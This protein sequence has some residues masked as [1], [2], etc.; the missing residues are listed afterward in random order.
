MTHPGFDRRRLVSLAAVLTIAVVAA[1]AY[2]ARRQPEPTHVSAQAAP[3]V[4]IKPPLQP[5]FIAVA[6]GATPDSNP[7]SLE[8]NLALAHAVLPGPG[9]LLFGSGP[10]GA[11]VQVLD[12]ALPRDPLLDALGE[13][14]SPRAGRDSRYES[15]SLPA[16][17]ATL[18]A[19]RTELS[20][21]LARPGPPMLLYMS[22]H[23]D[24]GEHARDNH[25]QLWGGDSLSAVDLAALHDK[26]PGRR[27]LRVVVTSCFSGGFAEL[28]FVGADSARGFTKQ[29]RCGLFATTWDLESSGCDPN[30]DRAEQEGYSLHML[31]AL[32]GMDRDGH[33]PID[34]DYDD[35]GEI[36][37]LEAHTRARIAARSID[38]PTTTSERF[39]REHVAE[40]GP[41]AI[42][43]PEDNAVISALSVTLSL[44][45]EAAARDA[46]SAIETAIERADQRL[47]DA[48][49]TS[50]RASSA[51][52]M[53]L[54]ER[55]PMIDDP[56]HPLFAETVQRDREAI[57]KAV[58]SDETA[59]R[60]ASAQQQVDAREVELQQLELRYAML[61]RLT[62]AYD[63]RHLAA[64][65][66]R[67]TGMAWSQYQQLL[68]CER[69]IASDPVAR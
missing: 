40:I 54:L 38:V 58:S 7:I 20:I 15:T 6:G 69:G 46:L 67:Q 22:G 21:A 62:R 64:A 56:W 5:R 66:K 51:L 3:P 63:N 39:L 29:P 18:T 37:L 44:P 50:D 23:G 27:Q 32:R 16:A 33:T 17:A 35:D 55:W 25:V 1:V 24:Q 49:D 36:T 31:N 65:L 26:A 10:N 59:Q 48:Q 61:S 4:V 9:V 8:Q 45:T 11:T 60:H 2:L 41:D 12:P 42:E 57:F 13:L 52:A 28:A 19:L 30:P 14:F 68:T 47:A 43:T 34:A 53:A